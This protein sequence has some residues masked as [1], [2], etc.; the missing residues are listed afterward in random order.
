MTTEKL[1]LSKLFTKIELGNHKVDLGL[2]DDVKKNAQKF[3]PIFAKANSDI[4]SAVQGF[5]ESL[6]TL[7]QAEQ[8]AIKGEAQL[9]DLGIDDKFF[10]NALSSIK[11]QKARVTNILKRIT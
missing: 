5:K 9:K 6:N 8:L 3:E 2:A 4:M 7:E 10:T 11:E 1:V